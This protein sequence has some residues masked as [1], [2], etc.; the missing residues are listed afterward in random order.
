MPVPIDPYPDFVNGVTV[1]D[2][3]Q[4]D[5]RFK[6]LY[7]ALNPAQAGIDN[8]MIRADAAIAG[9][10]LADGGVTSAKIQDGTIVSGDIADDTIVMGDLNSALQNSFLKL[11][12]QANRK[13]SFGSGLANIDVGAN[14]T[15][16]I[17]AHGLATTPIW[18]HATAVDE[19]GS[20]FI[21][22]ATL[23]IG[24]RDVNNIMFDFEGIN[25]VNLTGGGRVTFLWMAIG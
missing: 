4:V 18:G 9:S 2:G 24:G 13:V 6:A 17:Q 21:H 22:V 25:G 8:S 19:G 15:R 20:P 5:A 1:A 7:D 3:D 12:T 14:R 11:L 16:G 10:K 23:G